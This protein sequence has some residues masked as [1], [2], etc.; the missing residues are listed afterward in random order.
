MKARLIFFLIFITDI[1]FS[2]TNTIQ[3]DS[4][5]LKKKIEINSNHYTSSSDN[6]SVAISIHG[7]RGFKTMEVISVFSENLL[8]L[9]IDTIAPNISYGVNDRANEFLSCDIKHFHNRH[10]NVNEIIRWFLFAIE[11]DY[12]NII[13]IGHSR[14]GQDVMNAYEKITKDYPA[15]SKKI[16]SLVLLAPLTD[17]IDDINNKLKKSNNTT[18]NQLLKKDKDAFVKINFLSCPDAKVKVSSFLSY[19][20]LSPNEQVVQ[21]LKDVKINTYIFTASED[22]F[23]PKTHSKLSKISNDNVKLIQIQGSDHFFRDL[24][25]DEVIELLADFIG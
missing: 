3:L 23:V 11:K 21:I 19:Y 16:S 22:N 13:L 10:E 8:D 25:L 15:E 14:G 6:N 24:F 12:E 9:N 4:I 2:E 18:I 1:A 20:N 5:Y 7:T 17:D